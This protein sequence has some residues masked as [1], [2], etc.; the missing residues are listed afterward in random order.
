MAVMHGFIDS[1]GE[2]GIELVAG[3]LSRQ[4]SEPNLVDLR[5][6]DDV[7]P[8]QQSPHVLRQPLLVFFVC[9]LGSYSNSMH[10]LLGSCLSC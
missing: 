4:P 7:M 1:R 2:A 8:L 3:E 9:F 6:P 10:H 5:E